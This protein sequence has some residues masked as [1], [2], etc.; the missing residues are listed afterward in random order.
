MM[1]KNFFPAALLALTLATSFT[2]PSLAKQV[3]AP[4]ASHGLVGREVAAPSWS[5]ACMS[6]QGPSQCGEPVWM[7]D[8][9][10]KVARYRDAF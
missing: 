4:A 7:Y 5:A 9:P 2:A 6:D 3:V 8:T 1:T 10:A